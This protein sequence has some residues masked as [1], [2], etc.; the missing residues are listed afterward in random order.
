MHE[1]DCERRRTGN[2][3]A[4][5]Y[6][7]HARHELV[8]NAAQCENLARYAGTEMIQ[9]PRKCVLKR[10]V[11]KLLALIDNNTLCNRLGF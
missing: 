7:V 4:L 3:C 1:A 6:I 2:Y 9:E 11:I 8:S 5:L 10:L